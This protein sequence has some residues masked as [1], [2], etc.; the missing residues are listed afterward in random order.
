[1]HTELSQNLKVQRTQWTLKSFIQFGITIK[2]V[3]NTVHIYTPRKHSLGG[4]G[5]IGIGLSVHLSGPTSTSFVRFPP[6]FVAWV[7]L[8]GP[9]YP[10]NVHIFILGSCNVQSFM[11]F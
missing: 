11:N 9:G 5:Y 1:M 8:N 7:K 4:G 10:T 3:Y 2:T 6:N